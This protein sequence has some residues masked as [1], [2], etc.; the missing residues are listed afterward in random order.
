MTGV[1]TRIDLELAREPGRPQGDPSDRYVIVAP[2]SADDHLDGGAWRE[3]RDHCR[4]A[5]ESRDQAASLGH[6]VHGPGGRWSLQFDI[7]RDRPDEHGFRFE[8][9]R[10]IPGEYVSIERDGETHALRIVSTVPVRA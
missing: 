7:T 10:F 9:E 8:S 1:L 4:V 6:L 5:R 3:Q 2:L